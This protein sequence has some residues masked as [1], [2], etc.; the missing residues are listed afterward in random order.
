LRNYGVY[1]VRHTRSQAVSTGNME[2]TVVARKGR[3]LLYAYQEI[4][5]RRVKTEDNVR[6][7]KCRT[8]KQAHW[9]KRI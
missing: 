5:Y 1:N 3:G 8:D 2:H 9:P 7:L 6:Y 4:L